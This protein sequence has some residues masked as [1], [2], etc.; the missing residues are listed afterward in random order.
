[1]RLAT[2]FVVG[3][4]SISEDIAAETYTKGIETRPIGRAL[5]HFTILTASIYVKRP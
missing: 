5:R 4:F 1:L 3:F 2:P